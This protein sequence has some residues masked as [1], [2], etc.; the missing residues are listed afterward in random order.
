[1]K[2]L[3]A[4]PVAEIT[5]YL[6]KSSKLYEPQNRIQRQKK[7]QP[8]PFCILLSTFKIDHVALG[9][10]QVELEGGYLLPLS[11]LEPSKFT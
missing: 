9:E 4:P 10:G 2:K 7:H 8:F 3:A 5:E 6:H 1:M 11:P